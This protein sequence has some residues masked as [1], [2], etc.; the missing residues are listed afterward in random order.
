M[1]FPA[2][3]FRE[4]LAEEF[5]NP[6]KTM[7]ASV[8]EMMPPCGVPASVGNRVRFRCSQRPAISEAPPYPWDM[9]AHPV[10]TDVIEATFDVSFQHPLRRVAIGTVL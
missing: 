1:V 6:S 10:V 2:T 7:F 3:V 8:G 9:L 4:G 5:S